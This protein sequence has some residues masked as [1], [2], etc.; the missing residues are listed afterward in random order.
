[1]TTVAGQTLARSSGPPFS[2]VFAA[3]VVAGAAASVL[4]HPATA[5]TV[6]ASARSRRCVRS[7]GGEKGGL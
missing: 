3:E 5:A 6:A 1:M 4:E 2:A 7:R